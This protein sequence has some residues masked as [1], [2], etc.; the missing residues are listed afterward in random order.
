[1]SDLISRAERFARVRHEGQFR[2]G[3]AKEPYTNHLV[4]VAALVERWSGSESA[5]AAAWLTKHRGRLS[6]HL[7]GRARATVRQFRL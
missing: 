1:M 4:E 5:I 7:S 6:T 3:K 2:K